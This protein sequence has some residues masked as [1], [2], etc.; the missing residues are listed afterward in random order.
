M[1]VMRKMGASSLVELIR[2]AD[3]L[4]IEAPKAAENCP[5]DTV[6]LR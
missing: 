5:A 6:S 2:M 3:S 4:G 1:Q